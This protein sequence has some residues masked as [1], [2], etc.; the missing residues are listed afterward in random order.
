VRVLALSFHLAQILYA[1]DLCACGLPNALIKN[2]RQATDASPPSMVEYSS[3]ENGFKVQVPARWTMATPPQTERPREALVLSV[4]DPRRATGAVE[5]GDVEYPRLSIRAL[6]VDRYTPF[7]PSFFNVPI[8]EIS[9]TER[10]T[11]V[12]GRTV[13]LSR[14]A[15]PASEGASRITYLFD[16]RSNGKIYSVEYSYTLAGCSN[17]GEPFRAKCLERNTEI[18][19]D[20]EL[21]FANILRTFEFNR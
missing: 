12:A 6:D 9:T 20:G 18:A 16:L 3:V 15:S 2:E 5:P 19:E 4:E 14:Y 7:D 1:L 8:D 11:T 13:L 10:S 17:V 21:I